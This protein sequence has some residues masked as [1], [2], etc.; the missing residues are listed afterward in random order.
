MGTSDIAL[1]RIQALLKVDTGSGSLYSHVASVAQTLA[2]EKPASA[3]AEIEALS[4]QL[5]VAGFRGAQGPDE[6]QRIERDQ[7][8]VDKL[9]QWCADSLKLVKPPSDPLSAPKVLGTVSNFMEDAAMLEWAGVG[10]GKQESFH[11]AMSLRKLAA[12]LP[13]LERL[14]VW[15]KVLGT[16]GDYY[17][18]EGTLQ[19]VSDKPEPDP[20]PNAPEYDVERRGQG[21][22]VAC[23]WVS[24]GGAAPWVRLPAARASHIRSARCIR[25]LFTGSLGSEVLSTPWF[26]GKERHLL[27]SQIAR[28]TA[29]CTL[30]PSGFYEVDEESEV[31][32][33]LKEAEEFEFPDHEALQQQAT[34]VHAAPYLL[35]DGKTTWP[36]VDALAGEDSGISEEELNAMGFAK[37][38]E[39]DPEHGML[40][41]IDADLEAFKPEEAEGSVAWSIK[42]YG[43]KGIYTFNDAPKSHCATAVRSL[44]W[45]GAVTVAQGSKFANFY[46]GY[47]LKSG[48]LVPPDKDSGLPL[49]GTNAFLPLAPEDIMDEPADLEEQEE[50]NPVAQEDE[51]DK[52]DIDEEEEA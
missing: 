26:P 12:D 2:A 21:A 50:P 25:R 35:S 24:A 7:A 33:K 31:K 32:N 38:M 23:Y 17:V 48:S 16:G 40:E 5:K 15:G 19:A 10:F 43:D 8:A 27:R 44:I 36:D 45:P 22:N 4:R 42:Q 47:G 37:M 51:S 39:D 41:A 34:W 46:V 29:T 6:A 9:Q 30:A 20:L 14:R 3:L 1:E 18:A 28:I 49:K 13:S 52:G 11:V